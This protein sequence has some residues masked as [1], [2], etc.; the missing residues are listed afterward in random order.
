MESLVRYVLSEDTPTF[1]DG[2]MFSDCLLK[3]RSGTVRDPKTYDYELSGPSHCIKNCSKLK[4]GN[5][6]GFAKLVRTTI[7]F[8]AQTSVPR[9]DKQKTP[10]LHESSSGVIYDPSPANAVVNPQTATCLH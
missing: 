7:L 4:L 6:Q 9:R 5:V 3:R 8:F 2:K 10:S 1:T